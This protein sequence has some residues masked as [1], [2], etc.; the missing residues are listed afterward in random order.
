MSS[1]TFRALLVES[2]DPTPQVSIR[3]LSD[4]QL[5]EGNVTVAVHYSDLNYKDGLAV[6]GTAKV[7]RSLP[8]VPGID[9]AG[10][11]LESASA[12]YKPGDQV[13][14][15]GWGVGETHW[16]GFTQRNRVRSDW[17]VPLPTGMSLKH[18]MVIGTAGFTAMLCVMA[19]EDAGIRPGEREVLVTGAAGGVGSIAVALLTAAGYPVVAATGR[20]EQ[21]QD[22]LQS[23]GARRIIDRNELSS[24]KRPMEREQWAA[25]IDTVGGDVL[26]G[27]LRSTAYYG[28]VAACGN[29]GGVQ[30]TSSVFPFIL[31][32][33]HLVGVESVFCPS[34]RRRAAWARLANDLSAQV[35]DS[36][37]QVIRLEDIPDYSQRIINGQIRGRTVIKISDE[38]R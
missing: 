13:V 16:G 12:E 15:T 18:S 32:G 33:I 22:F 26:S 24:L 8:M 10:T 2:G 19:L 9:F 30:F 17:L 35:L 6:T 14:L 37:H 4:T 34:E 23:L 36:L 29:A 1:S 25:A 28:A 20:T 3:D 27:V 31:R 5:P 38:E 11:V 21:A 7:L